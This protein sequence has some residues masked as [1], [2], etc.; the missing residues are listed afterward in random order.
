MKKAQTLLMELLSNPMFKDA[1]HRRMRKLT[2]KL[3][4]LASIY[5]GEEITIMYIN[6][7]QKQEAKQHG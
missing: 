7:V 1:I 2:K 3:E 5:F 6:R 4:L